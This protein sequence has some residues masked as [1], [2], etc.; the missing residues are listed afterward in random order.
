[1][2]ERIFH[3]HIL[4]RDLAATG[5]AGLTVPLATSRPEQQPE[6][7]IKKND[8]NDNSQGIQVLTPPG[9]IDLRSS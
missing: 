9:R 3:Q 7:N 4:G 1:M 5:F 8:Q 2:A 6:E